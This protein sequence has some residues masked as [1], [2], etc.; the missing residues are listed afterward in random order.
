MLD[1]SADPKDELPEM[2]RDLGT[3][4]ERWVPPGELPREFAEQLD[5]AHEDRD[6]DERIMD[7]Y[8]EALFAPVVIVEESPAIGR[9]LGTL[10][11][12]LPGAY[13]VE[14]YDSFPMLVAYETAVVLVWFAAGPAKGVKLAVT[15]ATHEVIKPAVVERLGQAM[16]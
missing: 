6:I 8:A 13:I 1:T 5:N 4:Y 14:V 10:A 15:E 16:A 7:L 2:F 3:L 11:S 9:A 12:Q